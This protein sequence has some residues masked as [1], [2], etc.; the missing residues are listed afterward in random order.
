MTKRQ[1]DRQMKSKTR[2]QSVRQTDRAKHATLESCHHTSQRPSLSPLPLP[3]PSAT[4]L[5]AMSKTES[6]KQGLSFHA[7]NKEE[8]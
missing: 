3:P 1:S 8:N 4:Q 2:R 6:K 7:K 5:L